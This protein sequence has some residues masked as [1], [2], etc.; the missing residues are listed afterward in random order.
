[1]FAEDKRGLDG[2]KTIIVTPTY[3]ERSN[4][5]ELIQ[6]VF[7]IDPNYHLLIVDD[8]S[9][10]GTADV[11]EDMS[12]TYPN[13]HLKKRPEK[14]GLGT[15]YCAGFKL[16]LEKGFDTI[17]Q[18]DAD[19][20]HNPKDIPR[21]IDKLDKYDLVLGSRYCNG[22]SVVRWPIRRLILSY[23][24]NLYTRIVTGLPVRDA[25]G[26]F[27]CWRKEVLE[28]INLEEVHSEGYSFQIEMT[29]RAWLKGFKITEIPIIFIERSSGQSKMSKRIIYE[30]I[31]MV[32][33]LR[34]WKIFGWHK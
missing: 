18:I 14:L 15:A 16:A 6:I 13:L 33:R 4:I 27:K 11:V 28:N 5:K 10:D 9:P 23:G 1:M 8:N 34:L 25:T 7:S 31:L 12:I 24:A 30:A 26:G 17:I 2:M 29:F 32:W 20:S 3:N 22:V 19:L 21:L